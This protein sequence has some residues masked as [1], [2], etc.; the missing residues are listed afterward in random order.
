MQRMQRGVQSAS[1]AA[2]RI[3]VNPL[4]LPPEEKPLSYVPTNLPDGVP[5]VVDGECF[6]HLHF[7]AA[8]LHRSRG[9]GFEDRYVGHVHRIDVT[10]FVDC[11]VGGVAVRVVQRLLRLV[12]EV[13]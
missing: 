8:Q 7:A 2:G 13:V 11:N 10:A 1:W 12:I 5:F 3:V 9:A 6:T 4:K